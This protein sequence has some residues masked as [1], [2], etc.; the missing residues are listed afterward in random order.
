M[1]LIA[2]KKEKFTNIRDSHSTYKNSELSLLINI[3]PFFGILLIVFWDNAVE[4]SRL[5]RDDNQALG[6]T[7]INKPLSTCFMG[8]FC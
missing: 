2:S 7:S 1:V 5:A 6:T 3:L 8:I 4:Y